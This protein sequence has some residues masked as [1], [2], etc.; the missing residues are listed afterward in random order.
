MNHLGTIKLETERL[1]L[2]RLIIEDSHPMFLNWA[3]DP[4]VT[5]Y[6]SWAPHGNEEVTKD[7]LM[8]WINKYNNKDFYQ[9]GITLKGDENNPIG[10]ISAAEVHDK[11]QVVCI[12]YCIGHSWWNQG[13]TS[14]ALARVIEFFINEVGFNKVE[15]RHDTENPNS[16]RVM[17][18]C[19]MK[20]E[21]TLRARYTGNNGLC[22]C[23]FY[24][25][26]KS[27]YKK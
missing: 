20:Y 19:G 5:K 26:L 18:K 14:E 23:A 17:M 11:T 1:V 16:G 15:A 25:I 3:N 4:Q 9:W 21:G 7:V 12:G 22:D 2:R 27:E 13:I 24:G 6:L 10:T 8:E